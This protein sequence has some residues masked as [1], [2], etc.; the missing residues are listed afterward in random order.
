MYDEHLGAF[1]DLPVLK[2]R[3]ATVLDTLPEEVRDDLLNDDRF[4]MAPENFV[5]GKGTKIWLA[6]PG[7]DGESSRSVILREKLERSAE[8]FAFYVIAH[9]LAHAFL[10][11]GGWGEITDPEEAADALAASWGFERPPTWT[12][13]FN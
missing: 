3:I 6:T 8:P 5:P 4:Q 1:A 7:V 13:F 12:W 10:R 2:Q 9:E 11:N